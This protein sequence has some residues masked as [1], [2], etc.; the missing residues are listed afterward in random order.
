MQTRGCGPADQLSARRAGIL[1]ATSAATI[2]ASG[3]IDTWPMRM[4]LSG[5]GGTI[6]LPDLTCESTAWIDGRS[7][8]P[9]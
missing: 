8:N 3:I 6:D 9:N 7:A 4:K 5:I 2:P 1:D